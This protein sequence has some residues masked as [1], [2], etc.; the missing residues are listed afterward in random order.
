MLQ[1]VALSGRNN[2]N[3]LQIAPNNGVVAICLYI[4]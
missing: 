1:S 2:L 3:D 4:P